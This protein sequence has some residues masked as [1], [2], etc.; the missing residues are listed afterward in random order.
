MT[1]WILLSDDLYMFGPGGVVRVLEYNHHL[2][3]GKRSDYITALYTI[4]GQ[5]AVVKESIQI[6]EG[7][8]K[9]GS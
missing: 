9:N 2:S 5:V 4:N 3:D 6:I 1:Q 7:M 8:L